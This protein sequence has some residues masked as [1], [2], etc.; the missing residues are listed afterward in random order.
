MERRAPEG[1][2]VRDWQTF[3][4]PQ[5]GPVEIGGW[6][7]KRVRQNA[8]PE[9]LPEEE[10]KY[11]A[12]TRQYASLTPLVRI[13]TTA[14]ES[15][16]GGL[17]IVRALIENHG[18]LPTNLSDRALRNGIAK[19]VKVEIVGGEVLMGKPETE[20]GHLDGR[21]TSGSVLF[22][23]YPG[24]RIENE[25]LVEWLIRVPSGTVA[26]TITATSEKGGV[27]RVTVGLT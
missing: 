19:A 3:D 18:W 24:A 23:F 14:V 22:G 10:E 21:A 27:D 8:P 17:S 26:V 16:G 6:H 20:I 5:L 15:L 1:R 11:A 13:G 4:H 12:F 25:R 7:S 2:G 9:F